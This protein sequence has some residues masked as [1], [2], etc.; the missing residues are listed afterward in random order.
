MPKKI[1]KPKSWEEEETELEKV[2]VGEW[3][4]V[5]GRELPPLKVVLPKKKVE[6]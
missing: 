4:A 1:I 6:I 2:P 3:V 5:D